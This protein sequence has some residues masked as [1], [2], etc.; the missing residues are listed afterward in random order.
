MRTRGSRITADDW[1]VDAL[2]VGSSDLVHKLPALQLG[3]VPSLRSAVHS[4]AS[5]VTSRD[6][7]LP[8][9]LNAMRAALA[10]V[11]PRNRQ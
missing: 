6:I 10:V 1:N 5:L 4:V 11:S 7:T 2:E 3:P 9:A 8:V